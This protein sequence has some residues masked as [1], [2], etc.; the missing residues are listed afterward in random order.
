MKILQQILNRAGLAPTSRL[1]V[2]SRSDRG[3]FHIVGIFAD[4]HLECDCP[5]SV[6]KQGECRHIEIV[7][8]K[9][10]QV[11]FTKE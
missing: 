5:K 2:P 7:K 10:C 11:D 1:R 9:L 3:K 4:D 6:Y 8:K